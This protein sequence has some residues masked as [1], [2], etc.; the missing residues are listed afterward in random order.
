[1]NQNEYLFELIKT[2]KWTDIVDFLKKNEDYDVNIRDEGN[3]YLINY[4]ILF[5]KVDIVSL[6]IH[7]GSKLDITDNDG[8]SILY[9]PIKF[10]Y[11]ELIQLLLHFNES[12]I[13][14]SLIDMYDKNGNIPLHYGIIHK[15]EKA[16]SLLLNAGSDINTT[17][18]NG[19]NS[20]HLAVHHK[21]FNMCKLFIAHGVNINNKTHVGESALHIA[22][23]FQEYEIAELLINNKIE[24]DMQDYDNEFTPLHYA[25][26]SGNIK[27]VKLLID[28]NA[29]L[30]LQDYYGNT[31][32][33]YALLESNYNMVSYIINESPS[34]N[35]I[36][37]NYY[38][39]SSQLPIH[40][41]LS[42]IDY[43]PENILE[44]ILA[45]STVN[46]QDIDGNTPLHYLSKNGLW[47]KYK[48]ILSQK[49]LN[50]FVKNFYGDQPFQFID[51]KDMQEY[52]NMITN[53]YLYVLRLKSNVWIEKWENM[54]KIELFKDKLTKSE[55]DIISKYIKL[56][57]IEN[58]HDICVNIIDIKILKMIKDNDENCL[59]SS[60]PIKIN[61]ICIKIESGKNAEF[62]T[63]TGITLDILMG[64][65]YLLK[66][67]KNACSILDEKFMENGELCKYYRSIGI[68]LTSG[69]EFLNFEIVWV[70]QKLYLATNFYDNFS[71]CLSNKNKSFIIIP[72]GIE[73]KNG[74]HANYLIYNIKK[75]EVER[76]EP[77]GSQSPYKFD[78]NPKLLDDILEKKF[79]EIDPSITYFAPKDFMPKVGFQFFD[80]FETRSTKIGDPGGFCALWAIWYTDMRLTYND[81]NRS[82]LVK[83]I[84]ANMRMQNILFK[85]IVRNYSV[86]IVAIRDDVLQKANLTI[87]DWINDN[88]TNE[89]LLDV[90]ANI[91]NLITNC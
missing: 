38:N 56:D 75:K 90:T 53:S 40:I 44:I 48:S 84:I 51:E 27:L 16:V 87:N 85:N 55:Y 62:C 8:R 32:L 22:C 82:S 47:K 43:I 70:Y 57:N 91:T 10:N 23:N 12:Y 14:I 54:C 42:K 89:Q 3:N 61:K 58:N 19:F 60:Y 65:I 77:Y 83:K 72:I 24:I 15:N 29:N 69:C 9:I 17:D 31:A 18:K 50:I 20:L 79:K 13:G 39:I 41:L 68:S 49:K 46:V 33:H 28:N 34:K 25:I 63:F 26:N 81:I 74:S 45:G 52:I 5:N 2:H 1:M 78:Y 30:N 7:R 73:L 80:S 21:L 86:N 76:F 67:H 37:F 11:Y 6:L 35:K 59:K 4:A 71:R 64:L 36:N 88:F 66:K